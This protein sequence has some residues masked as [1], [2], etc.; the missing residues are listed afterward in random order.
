MN[1]LHR[2]YCRS[3]AW[4]ATVRDEL[5]RVLRGVELG[6]EVLE[7]GPGPGLTT[8]L[9]RTRVPRLTAI[10]IDPQLAADRKHLSCVVD[11]LA[12]KQLLV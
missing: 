1:R 10:E 12:S 3:G 5:P 6:D 11:R 4:A 2:W 8:D 7:V 9:L